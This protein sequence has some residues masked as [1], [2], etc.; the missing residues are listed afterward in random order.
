LFTWIA[1]GKLKARI[2]RT[3]PLADAGQAHTY[4]EGR[5]TKGKV[6]LIP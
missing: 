2:D 5:N 3:F 6:L 1:Q 4:L